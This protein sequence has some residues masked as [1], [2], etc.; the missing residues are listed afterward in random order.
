MKDRN[1]WILVA[2]LILIFVCNLW[3]DY[4]AYQTKNEIIKQLYETRAM[5]LNTGLTLKYFV[6][7]PDTKVDFVEFKECIKKLEF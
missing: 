7:N 6:L 4:K 1:F 5:I 2:L 3:T